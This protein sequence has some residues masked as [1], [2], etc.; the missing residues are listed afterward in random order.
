MAKSS[1]F[2]RRPC[3]LFHNK[4]FC[5]T[6]S[7]RSAAVI[8]SEQTLADPLRLSSSRCH[9]ESAVIL[10]LLR[11]LYRDV[12]FVSQLSA[13]KGNTLPRDSIVV[14][15]VDTARQRLIYLKNSR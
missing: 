9:S 4:V 8:V 15:T 7:A 10:Y 13:L 12:S 5:S 6:V 1:P 2:L 11:F 14:F 3:N